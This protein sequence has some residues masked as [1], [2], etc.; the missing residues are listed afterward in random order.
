[1]IWKYSKKQKRVYIKIYKIRFDLRR[2][3][4]TPFQGATHWQKEYWV[5]TIHVPPLR[6]GDELQNAW[7]EKRQD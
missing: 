3:Q 6:H 2:L 7:E 5:S 1:M 4:K